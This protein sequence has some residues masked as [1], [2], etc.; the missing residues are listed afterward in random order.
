MTKYT[1]KTR[2]GLY[3]EDTLYMEGIGCLNSSIGNV[4]DCELSIPY[5]EDHG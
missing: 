4:T 2:Y 5:Y 3:M 1:L